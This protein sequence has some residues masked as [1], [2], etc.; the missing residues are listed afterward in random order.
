[1]PTPLEKKTPTT[2]SR[3][4]HDADAQRE[5]VAAHRAASLGAMDADAAALERRQRGARRV[6]FDDQ[7]GEQ[8]DRSDGERRR[9]AELVGRDRGGDRLGA[10]A[11]T[12]LE[13]RL[14][15]VEG[16]DARHGVD[17]AG[18]EKGEVDAQLLHVAQGARAERRAGAWIDP[19]ADQDQ[20][21]ARPAGQLGGDVGRI[22][23]DGDAEPGR[24]RAGDGGV[25]RAG[26]EEQRLPRLGQRRRGATER[27]LALRR[28][29]P[30]R[31]Q[32]ARGGRQRQ[33]AAVDPPAF[34]RRRHFAQV[35]ADRVL[36]NPEFARQIARQHAAAAGET[37]ENDLLAFV[38]QR[39]VREHV[40]QPGSIR[41]N[42]A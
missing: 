26:V 18:A 39:R 4:A 34:S 19:A 27:R 42:H 10:P 28:L 23:G 20:L 40:S 6:G 8:R 7:V 17:R 25:G 32:R 21:D 41:H 12:P 5:R 16:G 35:A 22:G 11:M 36:G 1:M 9:R 37:F 31:R 13:L 29:E 14:L 15:R 3:S 33:C 38:E 24:Q 30:A 2:P